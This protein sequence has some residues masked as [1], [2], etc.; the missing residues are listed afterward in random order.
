MSSQEEL[1]ESSLE[2]KIC[3]WSTLGNYNIF[4][5]KSLAYSIQLSSIEKKIISLM[6]ITHQIEDR[7][8]ES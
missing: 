1:V 4:A 2:T 6:Q 8:F 7:K 3:L 5:A